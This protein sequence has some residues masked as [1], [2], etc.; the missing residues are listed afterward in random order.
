[1]KRNLCF[2]E[3]QKLGFKIYT[4]FPFYQIQMLNLG[5]KMWRITYKLFHVP[6]LYIQDSTLESNN[7]F[8]LKI[9]QQHLQYFLEPTNFD[10][11]RA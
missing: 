9:R 7:K 10:P 4:F 1:M 3:Y 11:A 6:P 5:D 8:S 2:A